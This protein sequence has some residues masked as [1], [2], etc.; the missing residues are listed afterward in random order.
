MLMDRKNKSKLRLC[1]INISILISILIGELVFRLIP[2]INNSRVAS[3]RYN[4]QVIW[5]DEYT[6]IFKKNIYHEF[7]EAY[8]PEGEKYFQ[9]SEPRLFR[10]DNKGY[11]LGSTEE[12]NRLVHFKI[13]F[14]GGSVVE[15]QEVD[16]P[17]R[18]SF[19]VQSILNDEGLSE[20]ETYN[21][22]I[23]GHTTFET[24]KLMAGTDLFDGFQAIVFMHNINDGTV[25]A[26][27]KSYFSDSVNI[28]PGRYKSLKKQLD[29]T[30]AGLH[31]NLTSSSCLV[32]LLDNF[33]RQYFSDEI[34]SQDDEYEIISERDIE[35]ICSAYRKNI[36]SLA[37]IA[38]GKNATPIFLTQPTPYLSGFQKILNDELRNVCEVKQYC[39]IDV[40][41]EFPLPSESLFFPDMVHLNNE[42][43]L[44]V[45]RIVAQKLPYLLEFQMR[46]MP[47]DK[48]WLNSFY[49]QLENTDN[50]SVSI[51]YNARYPIL[52]QNNETLYFQS[53]FDSK[54]ICVLYRFGE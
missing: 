51:P 13:L 17:F 47:I 46:E 14:S 23:R 40:A 53:V 19:A 15:C 27:C 43:S 21:L 41:A 54:R 4:S 24:I 39:L 33:M 50:K 28:K 45:A 44:S 32:Y 38:S 7:E 11:I 26:N 36:I 3:V 20:I 8:R 12:Q 34:I 35:N 18:F 1:L 31:E 48:E 10:T 25:L 29:K 49:Y 5:L 22:G 37:A 30:I 2:S 16:E 42:G 9:R 6:K 52:N